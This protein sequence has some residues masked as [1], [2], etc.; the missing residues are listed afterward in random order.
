MLDGTKPKKSDTSSNPEYRIEKNDSS[1]PNCTVREMAEITADDLKNQTLLSQVAEK[2]RSQ[3]DTIDHQLVQQRM[4]D[5]ARRQHSNTIKDCIKALELIKPLRDSNSLFREN[6]E[7]SLLE[8]ENKTLA[9]IFQEVK[10]QLDQ[11]KPLTTN[12]YKEIGKRL[13]K[14]QCQCDSLTKLVKLSKQTFNNIRT[15]VNREDRTIGQAEIEA[16]R[17]QASEVLE[18]YKQ[19]ETF[20]TTM[21]G[22]VDICEKVNTT[23]RTNFKAH[24]KDQSEISIDNTSNLVKEIKEDIIEH[25]DSYSTLKEKLHTYQ[26]SEDMA[27]ESIPEDKRVER[28]KAKLEE[29]YPEAACDMP[30]IVRDLAIAKDILMNQAYCDKIMVDLQDEMKKQGV[31]LQEILQKFE[32]ER[33]YG[34]L[35][36][37]ES[38]RQT[39][40][41]A[42]HFLK[43]DEFSELTKNGIL[44]FDAGVTLKHGPY[45]H[46]LQLNILAHAY[47]QG[48][49]KT[50]PVKLYKNINDQRFI[51]KKQSE[52][53]VWAV[54]FDGFKLPQASSVAG[55]PE[56]PSAWQRM[57]Q[58]AYS[59]P[60]FVTEHPIETLPP[61]PLKKELAL[62][63]LRQLHF[64]LDSVVDADTLSKRI[65]SKVTK[66][67]Q[68]KI[69]KI[70]TLTGKYSDSQILAK[71]AQ[72]E[73]E[74]K[75]MNLEQLEQR[76]IALRRKVPAYFDL[77][78]D[79]GKSRNKIIRESGSV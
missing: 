14:I 13:Y 31:S 37:P 67:E 21:K 62:T 71:K 39:F 29:Y 23:L 40:V 77:E 60:F 50:D 64:G 74:L 70:N 3:R 10:Q 44:T 1:K 47:N 78:G 28:I 20:L 68:D 24:Y 32:R 16:Y 57:H 59:N 43:P 72:L 6:S 9:Q 42:T 34:N 17:K 54:I 7:K 4:H 51:N 63:R 27:F 69:S 45:S 61:G 53:S 35:E 52:Y 75:G 25:R 38:E 76:Y 8:S 56:N 12:I 15:E 33:G 65:Q 2:L 79:Y 30:E 36:Q 66:I 58:Q 73:E 48:K 5:S 19:A 41:N 46:R 49:I 11:I 22:M 55:L 18:A 26:P